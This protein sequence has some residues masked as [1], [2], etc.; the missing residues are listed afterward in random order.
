[1]GDMGDGVPVLLEGE[2]MEKQER[3]VPGEVGR[4][5]RA[6]STVARCPASCVCMW[7][8][9]WGGRA[10]SCPTLCNSM[11]C[12]PPGSS[13]HGILQARILEWVAISSSMGSSRPRSPT[14]LL[15]ILHWQA[16]N[17]PLSPQE[18]L[19]QLHAT[20]HLSP[21]LRKNEL[22]FHWPPMEMGLGQL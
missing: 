14:R 22:T 1:M 13:V 10:Q 18:A 7:V 21:S 19:A 12:S 6:L 17:L 16:G 15:N 3:L 4:P 11:D 9:V 2:G 5:L 8:C 20:S